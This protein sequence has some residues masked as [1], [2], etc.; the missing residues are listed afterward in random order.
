MYASASEVVRSGLRLL[1]EREADINYNIAISLA[2]ID[3]GEFVEMNDEFWGN[4]KTEVVSEINNR[5]SK[6]NV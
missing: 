4:L 6:K 3:K 5:N 2:Q 1:R